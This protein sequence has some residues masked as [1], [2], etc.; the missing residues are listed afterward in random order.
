MPHDGPPP[1]DFSRSERTT[2][3]QVF[4]YAVHTRTLFLQKES[5]FSYTGYHIMAIMN[6]SI[7]TY[8]TTSKAPH[9][10]RDVASAPCHT[11]SYGATTRRHAYGPDDAATV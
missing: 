4:V 6:V 11:V 1:S 8:D 2:Y 10:S 9:R 7:R 5:V 3:P